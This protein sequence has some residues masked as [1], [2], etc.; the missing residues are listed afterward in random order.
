MK[1]IFT[2]G[3]V[4]ATLALTATA[5]FAGNNYY[6][7]H[8][9]KPTDPSFNVN[10]VVNNNTAYTQNQATADSYTGDNKVIGGGSIRTG[11]A[12]SEANAVTVANVNAT[13][14]GCNTCGTG[15]TD[16]KVNANVVANN[17]YA[18]TL[19]VAGATSDTGSNKII[20]KVKKYEDPRGR[21]NSGGS[22]STGDAGSKANAVTVTNVNLSKI[23]S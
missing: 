16:S 7:G 19:N 3:S 22:I 18:N 6:G 10:A 8:Y 17:N 12:K 21:D 1:K 20:V 5:T 4:I 14:I 15:K 23:G 9:N 11:D 13:Q 2:V